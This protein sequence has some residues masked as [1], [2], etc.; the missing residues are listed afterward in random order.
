MRIFINPL[1]K[2]RAHSLRSIVRFQNLRKMKQKTLLNILH[3]KRME[4]R[5]NIRLNFIIAHGKRDTRFIK[6]CV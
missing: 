4:I 2:M 3:S 6:N 1:V 5:S